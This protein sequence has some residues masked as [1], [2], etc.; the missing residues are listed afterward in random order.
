MIVQ[1]EGPKYEKVL[2]AH[3][4]SYDG[5]EVILWESYIDHRRSEPVYLTSH[6]GRFCMLPE[7]SIEANTVEHIKTAER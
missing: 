1:C 7:S 5:K 2:P 6:Y 4:K 3:A